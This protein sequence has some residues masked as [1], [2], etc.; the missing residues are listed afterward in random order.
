MA[1]IF[2]NGTRYVTSAL[3]GRGGEGSVFAIQGRDGHLVK[4]YD[5]SLRSSREPKVRAIVGSNLAGRTSLVAYPRELAL[6]RNGAFVGF[7]MRAISGHRPLH[8]LYSPK[9]RKQHFPEVDF[10]FLIRAALNLCKAIGQVHKQGCVIG[11]LN[12]SGVLISPQATVALIDADS[13]QIANGKTTFPCLVGVPEYTPPELQSQNLSGIIRTHDHDAFGLA[14]AIFHL[15]FLGRHPYAGRSAS[16]D[17]DSLS[18]CIA[19]HRFAYSISRRHQTRATPPPGALTLTDFPPYIA[20]SFELAFGVD[21]TKR[22]DSSHWV[23]A[24][25]QLEREQEMCSEVP[26]HFFH[27]AR[28]HCVW[29]RSSKSNG[30]DMF[31]RLLHPGVIDRSPIDA[32][33]A[34]II[35]FRLPELQQFM[36][37][38]STPSRASS[39]VA[40]A[41]RKVLTKQLT[42]IL[43][44]IGG[45][46]GAIAAPSAGPFLILFVALPCLG[47]LVGSDNSVDIAPFRAAAQE[48]DARV[49]DA[50]DDILRRTG[51]EE[52]VKTHASLASAVSRY[53][54]LGYDQR[55]EIDLLRSNLRDRQ[56]HDYLDKFLIRL[57]TIDGVPAHCLA[58]LCSFGIESAADISEQAVLRVPGFGPV[59]T[60]RLMKWR[61]SKEATFVF[62]P[63]VNIVN[64][65]EELAIRSRYSAQEDALAKQ[66]KSGARSLRA[67]QSAI[68]QL[69]IVA[70]ND[71]SLTSSLRDYWQAV[72]DLQ[73]IGASVPSP[74]ASMKLALNPAS[75]SAPAGANVVS[76]H[77]SATSATTAFTVNGAARVNCPKCGS[78][79]KRRQGPY[80]PFFG[81]VAFPRC[82]GTR[83]I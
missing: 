12:H 49:Q 42:L 2:V 14:V 33:I 76:R 53:R 62:D 74:S 63:S 38:T 71:A 69:H 16:N 34:S 17:N 35:A 57:S 67:A 3:V 77:T 83:N 29:C 72:R 25:N 26:S 58:V 46:S 40:D 20:D 44:C 48:A 30:L 47:L 15:L 28:S 54:A 39:R 4:I 22:P 68:S 5:A 61:R 51:I 24:L 81:C 56:L 6:D 79:M 60:E 78:T 50:V 59:R 37:K 65:P 52:A 27:R 82:R 55:R 73:E 75:F 31:P 11:D 43:G 64:H 1:E 70:S 66:I 7:L 41:R 80:G 10:R 36:P 23:R 32:D 19:K 8:E 18:D 21:P 9:S 13:F 45:V